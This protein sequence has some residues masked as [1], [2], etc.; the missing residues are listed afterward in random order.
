MI[1]EEHGYIILKLHLQV[2]NATGLVYH[3]PLWHIK[4]APKKILLFI[5]LVCH[6]FK[7]FQVFELFR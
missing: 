5:Y 7:I 4:K 6:F 2:K 3:K 1:Q